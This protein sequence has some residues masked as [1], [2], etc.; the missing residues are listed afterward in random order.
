M[1]TAN[2]VISLVIPK[3]CSLLSDISR[4]DSDVSWLRDELRSM[5]SFLEQADDSD[6]HG[7]DKANFLTWIDQ[8][9]EAVYD[10]EDI[11]ESFDFW[12][13][14]NS[15]YSFP[16]ILNSR[17]NLTYRIQD[18]RSRVADISRRRQEYISPGS[19]SHSN[20]SRSK[21]AW[22]QGLLASS[23]FTN[24]DGGEVVGLRED[25]E[26]LLGWVLAGPPELTVVSVV[27]MGGLGKTTLVKRV[28]NHGEVRRLFDRSAWIYVSQTAKLRD[29]FSDMAKRLME[30]PTSEID[31]LDVVELQE[32]LLK[33]LE[34]RRFLLVL[35]DVWRSTLWD[36]VKLV[37]PSNNHGS[38]VI[39]TTRKEELVSSITGAA[40]QVHRLQPLSPEESW[41]LFRKKAFPSSSVGPPDEL[42]ELAHGIVRKCGGLP[43]AVVTIGGMMSSKGGNAGE[44]RRV[45]ENIRKYLIRDDSDDRVRRVLMLSYTDLPYPI[46]CCFL[47]FS[48]FPGEFIISRKRLVRLW[49]SEG[50]V[51]EE[52][53]AEKYLMELINRS[54]VQVSMVGVGGRVKACQVHDLLH[55]FAIT[56]AGKQNFSAF[57]EQGRGMVSTNQNKMRRV[58]FH[59][60]QPST[61]SL[62]FNKSKKTLRSIFLFGISERFSFANRI[63]S[64]RLLRVIDLEEAAITK[65]SSEIGNLKHLRYLGLKGTKISNLPKSMKNLRNL[66]TLD[67]RRTQ[68]RKLQFDVKNLTNLKHLEMRQAA[69]SI[70]LKSGIQNLTMLQVATGLL[71]DRATAHRIGGLQQLRKLGLEKLN[72]KDANLLCGS[73]NNMSSLASLSISTQS[74]SDKL[75]LGNLKPSPCLQKLHLVGNLTRLPEWLEQLQSLTKLRLGL[76]RLREDPMPVLG[77][78]RGLVFLQLYDYAY[79]GKA[80]RNCRSGFERLKILLVTGLEGLEEWEVEEGSM[81]F[82]QELWIVSCTGLKAIPS[83]FQFLL[84]LQKLRL[85]SMP[86]SFLSRV[87]TSGSGGE[88]LSYVRHIASILS[89]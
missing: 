53:D 41:T 23:P 26:Q 84:T 31:A 57:Y 36:A 73:I 49:L 42:E 33:I 12:R 27:G 14:V 19:V 48:L 63:G 5:R 37:L 1:E 21:D 32:E 82:I 83:G 69:Q 38:R 78:L 11:I 6:E 28:F 85:V 45:L 50:F 89:Q 56:I 61:T 39:I 10:S 64:F 7:G 60:H 86:E 52:D 55:H 58:S 68:L 30:V 9:R 67:V 35:D 20:D 8:I 65:L 17:Y 25:L 62:K 29:I 79:E 70:K 81:P 16:C 71:A 59:N 22:L 46:K 3:L 43:L 88:D 75:E 72:S 66:Q 13:R 4:A 44:W 76:S 74:E 51:D 54:M 77:K 15:F 47:Y 18:L 80:M 2:M 40:S 24:Q 34:R 87:S